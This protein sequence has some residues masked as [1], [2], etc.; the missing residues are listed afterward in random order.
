MLVERGQRLALPRGQQPL[1][2]LVRRVTV[3]V[4][5]LG[6]LPQGG[7]HAAVSVLVDVRPAHANDVAE[8]IN[9]ISRRIH[10]RILEEG[11]WHFH[12]FSVPDDTGRLQHG[13][14]LYPLRFTGNNRRITEGHMRDALAYVTGLGHALGQQ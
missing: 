4:G 12:Q 10:A 1:D 5:V 6:E 3:V 7:R 14:T 2:V 8:R 11:R 9:T 13:A